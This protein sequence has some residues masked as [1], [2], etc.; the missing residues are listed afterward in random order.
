MHASNFPRNTL[1]LHTRSV[2]RAMTVRSGEGH[3]HKFDSLWEL[4]EVIPLKGASYE[5]FNRIF[6]ICTGVAGCIVPP[7][8]SAKYGESRTT[9]ET[10]AT[11]A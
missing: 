4:G 10:F 7:E 1:S 3:Q 11:S 5:A 2:H 9:P 8:L 6:R